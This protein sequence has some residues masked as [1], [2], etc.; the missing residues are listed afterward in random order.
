M[1]MAVNGRTFAG[2][3]GPAE[4]RYRKGSRE[5]SVND[6]RRCGISMNAGFQERGKQMKKK[7]FQVAGSCLLI[8]LFAAVLQ[9]RHLRPRRP[10][11]P[12]LREPRKRSRAISAIRATPAGAG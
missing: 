10:P 9:S 12:R 8:L 7:L 1:R 4:R 6:T 11:R 5:Q 2:A 3:S